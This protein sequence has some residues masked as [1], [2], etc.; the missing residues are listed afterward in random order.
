M[1][2]IQKVGENMKIIQKVGNM[3]IFEFLNDSKMPPTPQIPE[4]PSLATAVAWSK[5][6]RNA[7]PT[8]QFARARTHRDN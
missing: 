7:R 1:K 5:D 4:C 3:K 6:T 8:S 2:I